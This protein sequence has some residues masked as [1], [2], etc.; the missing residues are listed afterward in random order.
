MSIT[1]LSKR[2]TDYRHL[3]VILPERL[4]DSLF[5]T[6]AISL[7]KR[8]LPDAIMDAIALSPLSAEVLR[9]NPAVRHTFV[10]PSHEELKSIAAT[11]DLVVNLHP[12]S[13][14]KRI[15]GVM[16]L[17]VFSVGP[18]P[19]VAHQSEHATES[20]RRWLGIEISPEER[21]YTL[22]P[23]E[24]DRARVGALLAGAGATEKDI[25]IGCHI[26]CHSIAKRGL[27]FWKPLEHPKVWPLEHFIAMEALLRKVEPRIRLVLTG[28]KAEQGLGKRFVKSAPRTLNL[29]DA[30]NVLELAAL[31]ERLTLLVTSDTGVMHVGCAT[32]V[33]VL[34]LIGPTNTDHTGPYPMSADYRIVR[35]STMSAISPQV[36]ADTLL[37]HPALVAARKTLP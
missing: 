9:N 25:L 35:G 16:G 3:V 5:V 32:R 33:P 23:Q 36:A 12:H 24:A 18:V 19:G 34:A 7:L 26:G 11:H 30:T 6:P 29:I 10:S 37:E 4:G 8:A 20:V 14:A 15:C 13:E 17:D 1:P 27:K 2:P 28:S 21:R 31:M 22:Y